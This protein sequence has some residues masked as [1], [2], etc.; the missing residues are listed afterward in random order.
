MNRRKFL[1]AAWTLTFAACLS[2]LACLHTKRKGVAKTESKDQSGKGSV[3]PLKKNLA[4]TE[5]YLQDYPLAARRL[6]SYVKEV[7]DRLE[8]PCTADWAGYQSNRLNRIRWLVD[9][10]DDGSESGMKLRMRPYDI[11]WVVWCVGVLNDPEQGKTYA[12][13][14]FNGVVE[15]VEKILNC[16]ALEIEFTDHLAD[17]CYLCSKMTPDGCPKFDGYKTSF[18]QSSQ[19]DETLKRDSDLALAI[20]GLKWTDSVTARELLR[21]CVD[22][23]PEPSEFDIFPLEEKE[24]EY[25]RRGVASIEARLAD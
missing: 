11:P 19:M 14:A 24:W 5:E 16:P 3:M 9:T 1:K 20:V 2:P 22:K 7:R 8:S 4:R 15:N 17:F 18:P 10:K 25:Y 12:K 21:R 13:A 6:E 23:A